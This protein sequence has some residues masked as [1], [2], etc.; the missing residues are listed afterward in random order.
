MS[1]SMKCILHLGDEVDEEI[2]GF[3]VDSWEKVISCNE[4]RHSL[5]KTS[6]YFEIKLPGCYDATSGFHLSCYKNFTAVKMNQ[7]S[8][9]QTNTPEVQLLR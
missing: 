7:D 1:S 9:R 6:K 3:D 5:Y 2:K 4:R 8:P